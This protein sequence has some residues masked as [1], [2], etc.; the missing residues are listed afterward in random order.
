MKHVRYLICLIALT[1]CNSIKR[2]T[3]NKPNGSAYVLTIG[4]PVNKNGIVLIRGDIKVVDSGLVDNRAGIGLEVVKLDSSGYKEWAQPNEDGRFSF[5]GLPGRYYLF[6]GAVGFG[7]VKTAEFMV[8]AGQ[9]VLL[10]AV[11]C[12]EVEPVCDYEI[13]AP[14]KTVPRRLP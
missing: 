1:A 3:G 6:F 2:I 5:R 8:K 9:S 12:P 4:P 11:L 13:Q 10:E 14:Y 7:K